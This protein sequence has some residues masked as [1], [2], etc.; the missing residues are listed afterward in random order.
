MSGGRQTGERAQPRSARS[1]QTPICSVIIPIGG[2]PAAVRL[3]LDT[4][5]PTG[6]PLDIQ[7]VIVEDDDTDRATDLAAIVGDRVRIV[8]HAAGGGHTA[9]CNEGAAVSTGDYVAFVDTRAVPSIGWLEALVACA[10]AS[11]RAAAVGSKLLAPDGSVLHA[12]IAICHDATPRHVYAGF[13]SDHPAVNRSVR[14]QAVTAR[15]ALFRRADFEDVGGFDAA[16]RGEYAD[17]DLCLR[18]GER[19]RDVYYCHRAVLAYATSGSALSLPPD[20]DDDDRLYRSRWAHRVRPDDLD[21]Y[22]DDGL[23]SVEYD[24]GYPVRLVLSPLLAVVADERRRAGRSEPGVDGDGCLGDSD[25]SAPV[26]AAAPVLVDAVDAAS[27][28]AD[29][30]A[31]FGGPETGAPDLDLAT[32]LTGLAEQSRA[33]RRRFERASGAVA[34]A[35]RLLPALA[36]VPAAS[37]T[38]RYDLADGASAPVAGA[39][40]PA[41]PADDGP[42]SARAPGTDLHAPNEAE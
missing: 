11:P 24:E 37:S 18:L 8:R 28:E 9:A 33:S 16:F 20:R 41:D 10:D 12:G 19:G 4:L 38:K 34:L 26:D 17:V 27:G 25:A 7:V 21:R 15:C 1:S 23:L 13:P 6:A 5:L 30:P 35:E 29:P 39:K 32:L 42:T 2:R 14:L 3:W 40:S 36:D 22:Q 31:A